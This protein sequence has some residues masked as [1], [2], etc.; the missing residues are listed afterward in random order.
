MLLSLQQAILIRPE[1]PWMEAFAALPGGALLV[2][3]G[4]IEVQNVHIVQD[5]KVNQ[6]GSR[7][8]NESKMLCMNKKATMAVVDWNSEAFRFIKEEVAF[9]TTT[10]GYVCIRKTKFTLGKFKATSAIIRFKDRKSNF[11]LRTRNPFERQFG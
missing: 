5:F 7:Q 1:G 11:Y 2:L 10:C 8:C 4:G 6:I 3:V 9:Y